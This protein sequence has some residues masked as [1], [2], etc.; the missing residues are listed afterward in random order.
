[1]SIT[2]EERDKIDASESEFAN[3]TVNLKGCAFEFGDHIDGKGQFFSLTPEEFRQSNP[4]GKR[5]KIGFNPY[6]QGHAKAD[7]GAFFGM[8][9]EAFNFEPRGKQLLAEFS[10]ESLLAKAIKAKGFKMSA[11]FGFPVKTLDRI[12]VVHPDKAV[13]KG[14]RF[15]ARDDGSQ[16]VE[17]PID[18]A[19]FAFLG[20]DAT[21]LA[22]NPN[23]NSLAANRAIQATERLDGDVS[24][25]AMALMSTM[26]HIHDVC[27]SCYP[28]LCMPGADFAINEGP[29][30]HVALIHS[31]TKTH[32]AK[33]SGKARFAQKG[34]LAVDDE[35]KELSTVEFA[36][37]QQEIAKLKTNLKEERDLRIATEAATFAKDHAK[38]LP[39]SAQVHFA[40][41]YAELAAL[42]P[43]AGSVEFAYGPENKLTFKGS[44]LDQ[45]KTA[46]SHLK[47]HG[48]DMELAKGGDPN[49]PLEAP[50]QAP[51]G[52]ILFAGSE[53][54][55]FDITKPTPEGQPIPAKR[56]D[57]LKS[58][59]TGEKN[60]FAVFA[61]D[62]AGQLSPRAS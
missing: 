57:Y 15:F 37:M 47:P 4:P 42:A 40:Y 35:P 5:V 20:V 46:V 12:D 27:G 50:G 1:M 33:C 8:Y 14:A 43:T 24:P 53:Q 23:G 18:M 19:E 48:V 36:Q 28:G 2:V 62:G 56:A 55:P 52:L 31:M 3:D 59:L 38:V 45:L 41:L 58:F 32:G 44:I 21:G 30:K 29:R 39:A 25:P 51:N 26:Q 22:P 9:G 34:A 17:I 10:I 13:I 61:A 16:E 11:V 6:E 49:E 7:E 54:Q 60:S